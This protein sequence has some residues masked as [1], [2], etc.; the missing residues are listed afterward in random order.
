MPHKFSLLIENCCLQIFWM[1]TVFLPINI[2]E[3]CTEIIPHNAIFVIFFLHFYQIFLHVFYNH[4]CNQIYKNL[5]L[6]LVINLSS[7]CCDSP[8]MC[9][10]LSQ[11]IFYLILIQLH[12]YSWVKTFPI[13]S[14][15]LPIC[16]CVY[17]KNTLLKFSLSIQSDTLW[18]RTNIFNS[19]IFI[20]D[21]DIFGLL[22][23]SLWYVLP[24]I[25]IR[26]YFFPFVC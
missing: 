18:L 1:F 9:F 14:H 5:Y 7:L 12:Q 4:Y 20:A 10:T 8:K 13:Y 17:L 6:F 16:L 19:F 26:Y 21:T 22:S 23:T 2:R 25:C 24:L 11:H 3:T 15:P